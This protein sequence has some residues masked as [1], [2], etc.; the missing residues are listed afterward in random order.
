MVRFTKVLAEGFQAHVKQLQT[1][2]VYFF[3]AVGKK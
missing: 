1:R 2:V 3:V